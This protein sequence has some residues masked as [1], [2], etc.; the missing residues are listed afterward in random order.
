[1]IRRPPRSTRTDTLFP[2]TTLFRSFY[3]GDDVG[4]VEAAYHADIM[5]VGVGWGFSS[6]YE[7]SSAAPDIMVE[8]PADLLHAATMELAY[9]GERFMSGKNAHLHRGT[10]LGCSSDVYALGR[11]FTTVDPRHGKAPLPSAVLKPKT[12]SDEYTSDLQ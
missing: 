10:I 12:R 3:I 2:Y 9:I 5:S 4:D 11:Y 7:I 1:M 8:S 6:R